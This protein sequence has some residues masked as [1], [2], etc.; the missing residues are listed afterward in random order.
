MDSKA[1][2]AAYGMQSH[3]KVG[4]GPAG[5]GAWLPEARQGW[6]RKGRCMRRAAQPQPCLALVIPSRLA[7]AQGVLVRSV[8]AA[9]A[10]EAAALRPDDILIAI[11]GRAGVAGP[12]G[13][14]RC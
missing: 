12:E 4:A 13:A 11:G 10:S 2:K 6:G 9:A 14:V 8:A 3:Q 1:L 7:S 5:A